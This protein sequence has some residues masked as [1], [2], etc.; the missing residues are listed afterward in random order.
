MPY[1]EH[2]IYL[3]LSPGICALCLPLIS[4]HCCGVRME[5]LPEIAGAASMQR[6]LW[7]N[8]QSRGI[9]GKGIFCQ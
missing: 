6:R 5:K 3:R 9:K 7:V 1:T 2:A 4:G 8:I